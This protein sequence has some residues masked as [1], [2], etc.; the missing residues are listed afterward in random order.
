[1]S[2]S[3]LLL[4]SVLVLMLVFVA[5]LGYYQWNKSRPDYYYERAQRA[6]EKENYEAALVDLLKLLGRNPDHAAGHELLSQVI[7]LHA[8][9]NGKVPSFANNPAALDHLE[10]AAELQPTNTDLQA[11][12]LRAYVLS[13]QLSRAADIAPAVYADDKTNGD[14]HF[15]LTWAAVTRHND[16]EAERLFKQAEGVVSRHVFQ[17]FYLR[18]I[19]HVERNDPERISV[20]LSEATKVAE[21]MSQEQLRLLTIDDRRVMIHVLMLCQ[22][23]AAFADTSLRVS[24]T[25]LDLCEKLR[26]SNLLDDQLLAAATAHSQAILDRDFNPTDLNDHQLQ[27]RSELMQDSNRLGQEIV[28]I[29]ESEDSPVPDGEEARDEKQP[30]YTVIVHSNQAKALIAQGNLDAAAGALENAI[31]DLEKSDKADDRF[32][33]ELHLRAARN[34]AKLGR[35]DDANRH[36]QELGGDEHYEG[37]RHLLS[38]EIALSRDDYETA[39]AELT[40]AHELLGDTVVVHIPLSQLYLKLR[41]WRDAIPHLEALLIP[42][43][44]LSKDELVLR[45]QLPVPI[46]GVHLDLLRARLESGQWSEAQR[47]LRVLKDSRLA[48]VAWDRVLEYLWENHQR[49][50]A[51]DYLRRLRERSPNDISLIYRHASFLKAEGRDAKAELVFQ[52]FASKYPRTNVPKLAWARWLMKANK[53]PEKALRILDKMSRQDNLTWQERNTVNIFRAEAFTQLH[54]Y[55]DADLAADILLASP[56]TVAVGYAMKSKIAFTLSDAEQ[57]RRWLAKAN[58]ADAGQVAEGV[59]RIRVTTPEGNVFSVAV[60]NAYYW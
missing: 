8:R 19:Y 7:L 55:H 48:G 58:E 53:K 9:A 45:K 2:I 6:V 47:D 22:Q 24:K 1:M 13:R 20:V 51:W 5:C 32:G 27:L 16:E 41:Q 3:R 18:I 46:E 59:E 25:L 30:S 44:Q 11:R 29:D 28:Q 42:Y 17:E 4:W 56:D 43:D 21:G 35:F 40:R 15:A 34:Y 31:A 12:L 36:L 57:G 54:R 23:R 52:D 14:A 49:D 37:W 10:R 50:K 33:M 39:L 38:G 26:T 60:Q